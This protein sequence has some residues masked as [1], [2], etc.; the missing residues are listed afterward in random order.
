MNA[1]IDRAPVEER[2]ARLEASLPALSWKAFVSEK[3]VQ[4]ASAVTSEFIS[5]MRRMK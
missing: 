3:T 1:V 5:Q 4:I 2:M